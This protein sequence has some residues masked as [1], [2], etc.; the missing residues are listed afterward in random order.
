GT[1]ALIQN[2]YTDSVSGFVF[3][4]GKV[5]VLS[6]QTNANSL[7]IQF[8]G[9]PAD[10]TSQGRVSVQFDLLVDKAAGSMGN[11]FILARDFNNLNM[12]GLAIDVGSGNTFLIKYSGPSV[13]AG[14]SAVGAISRGT[15]VH[16]ELALDYSSGIESL[17]MDGNLMGTNSF[18]SGTSFR[19]I[20]M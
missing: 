16:L 2:T 9:S 19:G 20:S 4:N 11:F 8:L 7:E 5:A 18:A 13:F 12:A 3:G 6:D 1:S 14:S 17:Y 10:S 15:N